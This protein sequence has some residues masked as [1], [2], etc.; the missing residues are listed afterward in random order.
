MHTCHATGC[1]RGVPP[2]MFMCRQHWFSLP[3]ALRNAV[4]A[5]YRPGQEDDQQP[6]RAYCEAAKAAVQA[7]AVGEGKTPDTALYDLYLNDPDV[8]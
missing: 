6:S 4:W 7:V 3:R 1:Q 8:A 2:A 5:S